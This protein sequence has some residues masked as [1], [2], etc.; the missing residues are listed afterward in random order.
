MRVEAAQP[1]LWLIEGLPG[2]GKTSA[3]QRMHAQCEARGFRARWW[4]EE[5]RDHPVTPSPLRKTAAAPDFAARCVSAFDG[6]VRTE[7]GIL[8]L[9]GAAF[10]STVRFMFANAR[11]LAEMSGYVA[12][13]AQAVTS[14]EPR[15]LILEARDPTAH[16]T[17]FVSRTRGDLWMQ[18]LISYVE[19][20]PLARQRRW[21]GLDGFIQFW[22]EYQALCLELAAALPWPI[23]RMGA[24]SEAG[25]FDEEAAFDFFRERP[26]LSTPAG[27]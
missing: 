21:V 26:P 2:A 9:E 3:A 13:W 18:R 11:S 23:M 19:A 27:R 14:A 15:L 1:Q 25:L 5:A 20:T 16:Y 6:F 8:I 7:S 22:A 24:W 17:A 4:L 10:Q 12:A